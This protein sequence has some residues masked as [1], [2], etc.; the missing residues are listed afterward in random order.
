MPPPSSTKKQRSRLHSIARSC[1]R[2]G[3]LDELNVFVKSAKEQEDR[4]RSDL[5]KGICFICSTSVLPST[6]TKQFLVHSLYK[7]GQ[8]PKK[9]SLVHDK[10]E[11]ERSK[12]DQERSY[13]QRVRGEREE[14]KGE[15][16]GLKADLK[17]SQRKS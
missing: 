3:P 9:L 2:K 1:R 17:S 12:L 7:N 5:R 15:V 10:L 14:L 16:R 13:A 11:E 6:L 8:S 4:L